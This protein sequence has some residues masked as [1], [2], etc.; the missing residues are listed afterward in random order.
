MQTEAR[1]CVEAY[2]EARGAVWKQPAE[3]G[4]SMPR[5]RTVFCVCREASQQHHLSSPPMLPITAI[6]ATVS[7]G[8]WPNASG[9]GLPYH[10]SLAVSGGFPGFV[11]VYAATRVAVTRDF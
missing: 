11:M 10:G 6:S 1:A 3:S 5:K 8:L 4:N 9:L 7:F 2:T